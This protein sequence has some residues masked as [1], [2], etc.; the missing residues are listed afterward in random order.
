LVDEFYYNK[1]D[2]LKGNDDCGQMSAWYMFASLGFYPVNPCGGEYILGA[3]QLEKATI[4]LPDGKIFTVKANK[5][6]KEN[7]RVQSVSLNGQKLERNY[8]M[9]SEIMAG[10]ELVFEMGTGDSNQKKSG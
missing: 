2:G 5:L 9:H 4:H 1:P 7:Y 3:P 8:L 6:S 10:G